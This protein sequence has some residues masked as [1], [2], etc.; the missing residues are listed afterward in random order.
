MKVF[1][2]FYTFFLLF[3]LVTLHSFSQSLPVGTPAIEEFYRRTQLEGKWDS[4]VS[5]TIRPLISDSSFNAIGFMYPDSTSKKYD[6]LNFGKTQWASKNQQLYATLL[7]FNYQVQY[8]SAFP[9]GWNDGL[10][11]PAKGFQHFLSAG[12]YVRYKFLSVQ[13]KPELVHSSNPEFEAFTEAHY[14]VIAA[15]YHDFYNFIDLP[16]RFGE[17]DY[18][19]ITWGQSS[20]RINFDPISFGISNENLWWGPGTRNSLLMSNSAPGFKHLTLNTTRPVKT[21]IGSFESQLVA[22]K[23]EGSKFPPMLPARS[24]LF[25]S[26]YVPKPD[27]WRYF[28][29]LAFTWQPKWVPGLFLGFSRSFQVYSQDLGRKLGDYLPI[30]TPLQ[31]VKAD[32]GINKRDQYSSLFMRWLWPE[33]RAEL[34]FEYGHSSP[35]GNLRDLSLEPE[36]D[37]AYIFGLRKQ[38]PFFSRKDEI[39]QFNFELTQLQQSTVK[40]VLDARAWYINKY[41]RHGYTHQGQTLGAGIGPGGNSQTLDISWHKGLKS[42]GLQ[43]ERYVHNNDFYYYAY[44]DSQDWRR[45]WVDISLGLNANWNYKNLLIN[46][47]VKHTSAINYQWYLLQLDPNQYFTNGLDKFNMQAQVGFMYRF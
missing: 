4:Q 41:V 5:F 47:T 39:I 29:G 20:L 43:M 35:S 23:L 40:S 15:R 44:V 36:N 37:R 14:D 2:K 45:H 25:D 13:L 10:M 26:L 31:K 34:Y 17:N 19:K 46:A 30:F 6:L 9:Y 38:Y 3:N 1:I 16:Q 22:G 8:N 42:I 12:V 28:S 24:Y 7:P 32:E 21:P 18:S 33:E 11:I 27:D